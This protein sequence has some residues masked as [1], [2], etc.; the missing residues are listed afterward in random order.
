MICILI[1]ESLNR[2]LAWHIIFHLGARIVVRKICDSLRIISLIKTITLLGID[3]S[4]ILNF[5]KCRIVC[6]VL[7]V[8]CR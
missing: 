6:L 8:F 4:R 2:K 3:Y 1:D 5:Y 7:K